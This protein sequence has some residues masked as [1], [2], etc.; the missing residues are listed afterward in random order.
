MD[1]LLA[2]LLADFIS[3]FGHW[4][5]D[6]YCRP[7]GK[8]IWAREVCGP[9]LLHHKEP[10]AMLLGSFFKRNYTTWIVASPLVGI[11][12]VFSLPV[13]TIAGVFTMFANET[14]AWAHGRPKHW[15]PQILQETCLVIT[16]KAHAVH[17]KAPHMEAYCTLGNVVNPVLDR[18]R[19][20]R[21]LEWC[22]G[23]T[24]IK[25]RIE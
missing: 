19:F 3:G 18:T 14:H 4:F 10:K 5:E 23:L 7:G 12:I 25:P 2:Y 8:G 11:G 16:P 22:V 24:G 9:N 13:V 15:L 1:V 6:S 17:H 20:W 21:G